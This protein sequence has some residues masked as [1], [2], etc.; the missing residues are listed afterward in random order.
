MAN[1]LNYGEV[2]AH[3]CRAEERYTNAMNALFLMLK[4]SNCEG[5]FVVKISENYGYL[6]EEFTNNYYTCPTFVDVRYET[7]DACPEGYE[8]QGFIILEKGVAIECMAIITDAT[9]G[10]YISG[11]CMVTSS[12][13]EL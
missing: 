11:E 6:N 3:K 1:I 7:G 5:E 13:T 8:Y 12:S 2:Q 10:E 9:A 4:N